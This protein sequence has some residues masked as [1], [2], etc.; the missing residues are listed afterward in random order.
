MIPTLRK[1][2]RYRCYQFVSIKQALAFRRFYFKDYWNLV[3]LF[4]VALSIVDIVIDEVAGEATGNFSPSVLK[5]AKVFRV[6]RMGRLL[7]LFKVSDKFT[8][9]N[10]VFFPFCGFFLEYRCREKL[11]VST[12]KQRFASIWKTLIS[13]SSQIVNYDLSL[14]S[15]SLNR[16]VS[17]CRSQ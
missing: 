14:A 17:A 5:V 7:R 2:C 11:L 3:D 4:I 12:A 6:L 1:N 10:H 8:E 13:L 15:T 9:L 16:N